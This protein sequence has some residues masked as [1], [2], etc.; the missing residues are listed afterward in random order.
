M[1]AEL[2]SF[3]RG[4]PRAPT[5]CPSRRCGEAAQR[6]LADD[7]KRALSYG[8]GIGHPGLCEWIAERHGLA[9]PAQVM[10]TNGSLEAGAMLFQHLIAPGDRVIVEQP[11]YDRTLLLLERLGAERVGVPLSRGRDRRRGARARPWPRAPVEARP[12]DPQLPQPRRLHAL[13]R[14]A[15]A[16]RRARRRA[17][18]L[19]LRGRPLP[20]ASVRGRAAAD[21]AVAGPIGPG[22]PLVLVL[23]DRQPGRPGRLPGRARGGDHE[24]RQARQR[25]LHLAEHARRVGGLGALPL[26]GP[27][28]TT[29]TSSRARCAS[30]AMPWSTRC[31][32]ISPRPSS[33]CPE[34]ATSCG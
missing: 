24:A 25:G 12:R 34:A 18:L 3:A 21:D 16:P 6:A 19:D 33:S 17:R 9:D 11:S 15:R 32:S 1:A 10:V 4:A 20:R 8:T 2:I 13:G 7:W 22:D 23:E 5:S 29:S 26:R 28:A 30:G 31:A 27:R 14:Q